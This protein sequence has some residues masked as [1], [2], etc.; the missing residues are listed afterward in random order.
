MKRIKKHPCVICGKQVDANLAVTVYLNTGD[1]S[2]EK[3]EST[4]YLL[5]IAPC[6]GSERCV[7]EAWENVKKATIGEIELSQSS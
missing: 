6:C 4:S 5:N 2:W 3:D 7:E 1:G